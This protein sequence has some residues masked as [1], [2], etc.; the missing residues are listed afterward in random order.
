MLISFNTNSTIRHSSNDIITNNY[1]TAPGGSAICSD[2]VERSKCDDD[3]RDDDNDRKD[4]DASDD[5]NDRKD[6]DASDDDEKIVDEKNNDDS[7]D[8]NKKKKR[9]LT[10][11][12][13]LVKMKTRR[14][15]RS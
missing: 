9:K 12:K 6:D 3:A 4:D 10:N 14:Y 11:F 15:N 2:G 8:D 1:Y 13:E 5:D 7:D